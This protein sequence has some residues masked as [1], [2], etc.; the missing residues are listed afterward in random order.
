[1]WPD[2]EIKCSPSFSKRCP[3][4]SLTS[5]A[6][7]AMVFS[8]SQKV[9]KHLGYFCNKICNHEIPKSPNLFTLIVN[10]KASKKALENYHD[11]CTSRCQ[12]TVAKIGPPSRPLFNVV[13]FFNKI[14]VLSHPSNILY[15]D[16]NLRRLDHN[17]LHQTLTPNSCSEHW[18]SLSLDMDDSVTNLHQAQD[19]LK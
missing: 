17:W 5:S 18:Y 16:L 1:M 11:P 6:K 13:Q 9:T 2:V 14:L 7:K 10:T 3:K 4:S 12:L 15:R 8:T 19:E